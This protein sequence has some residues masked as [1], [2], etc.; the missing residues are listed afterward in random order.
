MLQRIV[1]AAMFAVGIA[2][3]TVGAALTDGTISGAEWSA[4]VLALVGGF[5]AKLSDNSRVFSIYRK[6]MTHSE[7]VAFL[8]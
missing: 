1:V 3:T 6:G 4:I 5:V 7:R 8:K 2:G